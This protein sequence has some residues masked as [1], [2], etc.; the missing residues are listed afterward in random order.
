MKPQIDYADFSKLDLRVGEVVESGAVEGSDKLV[1]MVV[2]FGVE[3]GKRT[4]C[5]GIKPW[6]PP[7]KLAGRKLAFVVNLAPKRFKIGEKEYESAGMVLAVA[8]DE[9]A[10]LYNFDE[11]VV[12]GSVVR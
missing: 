7:E 12:T 5:A 10:V 8:S 6:Y 4:I 1:R 11:D 3:L 9:K 2:D